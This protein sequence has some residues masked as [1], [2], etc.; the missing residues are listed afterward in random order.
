[1][2]SDLWDILLHADMDKHF[3]VSGKH[4]KTTYDKL[5]HSFFSKQESN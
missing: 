5:I 4:L 2:S 1:M 3:I